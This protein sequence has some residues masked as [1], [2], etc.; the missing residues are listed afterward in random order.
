MTTTPPVVFTAFANPH[1][2]LKNLTLEQNGIQDALAPLDDAGRIRHRIRTGT[3]LKAYFNLLKRWENQVA[4]FHFAGHA[5]SEALSLQNADT[6]FKPLAEEL[7]ARQKD[8]LQLVFLNGCST[9]AHVQT[10]FDL[11]APAV[12]ATS[13]GV[14]DGRAAQFAVRFYQNLAQGDSI[15]A[16]YKSAAN[17]VKSG[18]N[19]ERFRHL[20]EIQ[21]WRGAV[22]R[23]YSP[24]RLYLHED[25]DT[26]ASKTLLEFR[27]PPGKQNIII[28]GV[29][30]E[31][32]T[33]VVNGVEERIQRRFDDL[34]A[35]LEKMQAGSVQ[36]DVKIYKP[37]AITHANF[38]FIV[39]QS[40]HGRVLPDELAKQLLTK[41]FPWV[42]SLNRE[43][44]KQEVVVSDDDPLAIFEHYGWLIGDSL[45]KMLTG[46][47]QETSLVKLSLMT[48]T[49]QNSLRY[50][51]YIQIAQLLGPGRHSGVMA[52]SN[53]LR[54][55]ETEHTNY[56][57]LNLLLLLTE[58]LPQEKAFIPEINDL[59]QELS[60]ARGKLYNTALFL[61]YHRRQLIKGAVP[62]DDN[63]EHLIDEYLTALVF[64]LR[65]ISFLARYRLVSIKDIILNY[66]LGTPKFF[67]HIYGE[68]HALY[69][70][71][72]Q[73]KEYKTY[74]TRD[75]F[76]YNHSVLLFKGSDMKT[77]L[78][79]IEDKSTF[80]SL[81][82]LIID[83]SVFSAAEKQTPEI[84]YF[85]GVSGDQYIFS[86]YQN[87]LPL[88]E[89]VPKSNKK[90][91]LQENTLN[92]KL[93]ELYEDVERV[94]NPFKTE[95]L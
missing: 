75:E 90:F 73:G 69:K 93:D 6:F 21:S 36:T 68:L 65:K 46:P 14:N 56:D 58:D 15:E 89:S 67:R 24:W 79:R 54:H 42:K 80:I 47:A 72:H 44:M 1:G 81:T 59:V 32:I 19:E 74:K 85:A 37:G 35:L 88:D 7:L 64:W 87:E 60:G 22:L 12:I 33:V 94:F 82:P 86:H 3:G 26:T 17:F 34:M 50:L 83:Y 49:F 29:T 23:G 41:D 53:Y 61:D 71:R 4:I 5:N 43:L 45:R 11:G 20:G 10:L 18:S 92:D 51:C 16:A 77:N 8:S 31:T 63:L 28:Q 95:A 76:T 38:D 39:E 62:D 25:A 27:L 84:M 30:A 2:D 78:D 48:E 9:H 66:R 40:K 55:Q 52:W 57:F 91:A 70:E 13:A